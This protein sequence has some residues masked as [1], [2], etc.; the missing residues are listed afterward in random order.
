MSGAGSDASLRM[1]EKKKENMKN[2]KMREPSIA[3]IDI[4]EVG[5]LAIESVNIKTITVKYY[6]IDAEILFSRAPFLKNNTEEFSYVK[7]FMTLEKVMVESN[8]PEELVQ[9]VKKDV[10]LPEA[11]KHKN[12]VIEIMG[13][14]QQEFKTFYSCAMKVNIVESFGELKVVD[15]ATNKAVPEVYVKVFARDKSGSENFYRDGYTD[16]R[17]KFEYAMTSGDKLKDVKKFAILVQS[18][19]YGSQIKEVDPPVDET[20]T[21]PPVGISPQQQMY[22]PSCSS[23]QQRKWDR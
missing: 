2:S 5:T 9:Y 18:D 19:T 17:G 22:M 4:D 13:D 16:I 6:I 3:H 15:K 1:A 7:P 21:A 20:V 23:L 8:E 10:E 14:D 11:L 12:L